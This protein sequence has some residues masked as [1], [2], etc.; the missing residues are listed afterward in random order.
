MRVEREWGKRE[1]GRECGRG[2][3]NNG[4]SEKVWVKKGL[5]IR[6]SGTFCVSEGVCVSE[7]RI[8]KLC[9]RELVKSRDIQSGERNSANTERSRL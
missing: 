4:V 6:E 8:G 9:E 7:K 3:K 2:L 1:R 5:G